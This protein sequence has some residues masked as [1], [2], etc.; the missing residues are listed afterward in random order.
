M[1][2]GVRPDGRALTEVRPIWGDVGLLAR[3]HGSGIFTRGQTQVLS[4]ATLG[5]VAE[6]QKLADRNLLF[7]NDGTTRTHEQ[8]VEQAEADAN[9]ATF[10]EES[11]AQDVMNYL[12][13]RNPVA[14]DVISLYIPFTGVPHN[15]MKRNFQ[16]S[17]F[18]FLTMAGRIAANKIQGRQFDQHAFVND[19]S[20]ALTGT[21]GVLAGV[22]LGLGGIIKMGTEDEEKDK[23]Y[24][25]E[26]ALGEQYTPY[27]Y[28]PTTETYVSM[29]TFAPSASPLV[30]GASIG[31][32]L[33]NDEFNASALISAM[34]SSVDSIFDASYLSG[35]SDLFGGY[36]SFAENLAHVTAENLSSQLTPAFLNQIANAMDPYVRETKD[37]DYL[38]E[39]MKTTMNRIPGLRNMLPEKVTVAGENVMTKQSWSLVDPFTRTNP[40]ENAALIEVK[41]LYDVIGDTAVLPSDALRSRKNSLTLNKKSVTLNDQQK[42]EYKKYYGDLWTREVSAL[43]ATP[44]YQLMSDEERAEKV[45]KIMTDTLKRAKK[46]FID[47]YGK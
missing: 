5:P 6:Q 40:G 46:E 41:R 10:T 14:A 27:V 18:G 9:Y 3:T 30:W 12:R 42:S 7:N 39:L 31:Q 33:Q 23:V 32:M 29:S 35:L 47:R 37:K 16:Y 4:I 24:D 45:E 36:G 17:P 43:M 8:M 34:T 15:I 20:R 2:Q 26:T 25:V 19:L 11:L 22:M 21:S 44:D 38:I 28:D 1:D 13:S